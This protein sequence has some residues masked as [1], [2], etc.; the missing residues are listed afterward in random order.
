MSVP[1][2]PRDNYVNFYKKYF[3]LLE[4]YIDEQAR[5]QAECEVNGEMLWALKGAVFLR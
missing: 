5:R 4:K 1:V 2:A 3:V